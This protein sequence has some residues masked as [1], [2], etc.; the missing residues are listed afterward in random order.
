M[1]LS[2]YWFSVYLA[3]ELHAHDGKFTENRKW[4]YDAIGNAVNPVTINLI[5]YWSRDF[6]DRCEQAAGCGPRNQVCLH[7]EA[8]SLSPA[9]RNGPGIRLRSRE[10]SELSRTA[11]GSRNAARL[12]QLLIVS[13]E[14][15]IQPDIGF[16]DQQHGRAVISSHAF[17]ELIVACIASQFPPRQ[18]LAP[19]TPGKCFVAG[20]V[21]WRS[22]SRVEE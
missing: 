4:I 18:R 5:V 1:R 13:K 12:D 17:P 8:P 6:L 11:E 10:S 2:P 20:N 14:S 7:A 19:D 21:R 3:A 22:G 15:R 9:P 16:E